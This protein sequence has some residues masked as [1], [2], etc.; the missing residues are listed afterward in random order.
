MIGYRLAALVLA[1]QACAQTPFPRATGPVGPHAV[2]RP[3]WRVP[4]LAELP[5]FLNWKVGGAASAFTGLTFAEAIVRVDKSELAFIEGSDQQWVSPEIRK[6][7]DYRLTPAE[8]NIVKDRLRKFGLKMPAYQVENFGDE[9]A[10]RKLFEFARSLGVETIV[11]DN[12]PRSLADIDQLANEFGVNVAVA[13]GSSLEGRSRRIG[14]RVESPEAV[15]RF[16]DRVMVVRMRD[17]HSFQKALLE[18]YRLHVKPV[19]FSLR[20]AGGYDNAADLTRAVDSFEQAVL[21]ELG[22][23]MIRR[24]KTLAIRGPEELAA[25]VKQKIAAAIPTSAAKAAR[26]RRLLILDERMV[27][28]PIPHANYA[29][30]LMG[31]STGAFEAVFSNDLE[32]LQYDKV[33]QFD[34]VMFNSTEADVSADP[35]VREGLLRFVREGGGVGGIHAASWSFAFWPEFMEMFGA[36]Q[37]PHR[38]QPVTMKI[39][40][41]ASPITAAFEGQPITYTDEYYRMTD[42]GPQGTYYSRD[43]AHVLLSVDLAKTPDFNEGRVPFQRKDNDYA[44]A[45]IKGYGKGRVF[46]TCLGHTPEMFFDAKMN[47]FLLAAVQFILGDLAA[48]TTPSS[49]IGRN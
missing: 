39:D 46:Y 48:D 10:S 27:H 7:L 23:Y 38:V 22:D 6:N 35:A 25:D 3:Q 15:A 26:P 24:S 40:D 32:N 11:C 13:A 18:M 17:P 4:T 31:K 44:V 29:L 20:G 16:N 36:S 33:R 12:V 2:G 9:A 41:L 14:L 30:E 43:K 49:E 21:P 19:F 28:A 45:W 1:A 42:S 5:G 47:R 34:A 37:G 8:T